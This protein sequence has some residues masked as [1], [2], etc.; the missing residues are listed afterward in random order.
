MFRRLAW[1]DFHCRVARASSRVATSY[2]AD[3]QRRHLSLYWANLIHP[4][5]RHLRSALKGQPGKFFF[6]LDRRAVSL[7]FNR[8][9]R[10]VNITSMRRRSIQEALT[11]RLRRGVVYHPRDAV[12]FVH[13]ASANSLEKTPLE[14]V[15]LST[16]HIQAGHGSQNA[17]VAIRSGITLHTDSC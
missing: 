11:W 2:F 14:L 15:G 7:Q 12:N 4:S 10:S 13:N 3:P 5:K 9:C 17:D 8:S 1:I 6:E 16:H